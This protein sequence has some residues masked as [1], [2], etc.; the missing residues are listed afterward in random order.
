M[1]QFITDSVT[2]DGT[3]K[4]VHEAIKGGCKWIQ[5]RMKGIAISEINKVLDIVGP[6]CLQ[7]QVTLIVD[8]HVDLA[9]RP[10]VNGVHLGQTDI[11]TVDASKILGDSKIIGLTINTEGQA[12]KAK[13]S[14]ADY[15]GVGPWRYTITKKRLAPI[16]GPDGVKKII[17]VLK[18]DSPDREVVV[19]GGVRAED[20][21]DILSTG[22]DG[23]A[24][25][26]AITRAEDP[27]LA[28]TDFIK[29]INN[30]KQ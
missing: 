24:V 18:T 7:N 9:L 12:L 29:R 5:I 3:V 10:D 20:V 16:L 19:I 27:S 25:S 1:L 30:Q 28:T 22:A 21:K 6:V 8:D 13:D 4:Q 26:G 14:S 15:Y 17:K 11:S 2:V 23:I